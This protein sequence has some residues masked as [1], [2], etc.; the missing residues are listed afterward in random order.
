MDRR[1]LKKHMESGPGGDRLGDF[2]R[3]GIRVMLIHHMIPGEME[4]HRHVGELLDD[5]LRRDPVSA[6][7]TPVVIDIERETVMKRSIVSFFPV[8]KA[9]RT[10]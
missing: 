9:E 2:P 8:V 10:G 5:I 1:D 6:V 4:S 7:F 3:R